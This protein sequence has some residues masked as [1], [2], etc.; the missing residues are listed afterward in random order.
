[1]NKQ[2][3]KDQ[4]KTINKETKYSYNDCCRKKQSFFQSANRHLTKRKTRFIDNFIAIKA[5]H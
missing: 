1:M 3:K 5:T 2:G 4:F